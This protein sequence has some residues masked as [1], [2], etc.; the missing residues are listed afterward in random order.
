M[1]SHVNAKKI[2]LA[3]NSRL[4]TNKILP[5]DDE[6]CLCELQLRSNLRRGL[7][8][9]LLDVHLQRESISQKWMPPNTR[10]EVSRGIRWHFDPLVV[11]DCAGGQP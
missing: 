2:N 10:N 5:I 4:Q 1:I 8:D 9:T 3:L 11:L 7:H 6:V